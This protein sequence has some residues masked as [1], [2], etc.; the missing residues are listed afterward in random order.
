MTLTPQQI[1]FYNVFGYL[2][3]REVFSKNEMRA[4]SED[5]DAVA[6]ADREG[7]EF[8]GVRRQSIDLQ[9]TD[10]FGNL[11]CS[12]SLYYPLHQLLGDDFIGGGIGGGLFVGDT[13][14]H[15]DVAEVATQHRIKMGMYLDPV[16]KDSGCLRVIP[17]SHMNP[18]HES[19][20]PLRMGR[21][22]EALVDGRLLSN[23][24]P[25]SEADRIELEAWE[26]RSGVNLD[27]NDTIFGWDPSEIP[28]DYLESS[29]GDV[30]LFSQ[31]IFHAAFGGRDGRRMVSTG[32]FSKP[33]LHDAVQEYQWGD[34]PRN[35]HT[36]RKELNS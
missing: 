20:Q 9:N 2:V 13:Q 16:S 26:K 11:F 25:A 27:D 19:L 33:H 5:F 15:P 10:S 29:P 8:G 28:C 1:D 12:D 32:W 34:R 23:I 30:V 24:A 7:S 4:M 35:L 18:L 31:Y 14:W 36:L 21:L 3:L 17:G 6:L 22:K